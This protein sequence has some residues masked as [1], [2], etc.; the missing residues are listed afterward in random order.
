MRNRFSH[1]QLA[2]KAEIALSQAGIEYKS[3]NDGQQLR[4]GE[5]DYYPSTG[6]V[7]KVRDKDF[8]ALASTVEKFIE[9]IKETN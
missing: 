1:F 5:Y 3:F 9:L 6:T 7:K 4:V 8:W 2:E